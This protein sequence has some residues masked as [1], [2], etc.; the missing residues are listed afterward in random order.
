MSSSNVSFTEGPILKPLLKFTWPIIC[1]MFLQSAYSAVDLMILG[2]YAESSVAGV[3]NGGTIMTIVT[4]LTIGLVTGM[5]VAAGNRIGAGK[6]DE[7]GFCIGT[8]V[9]FFTALSAAISVII[10]V[11]AGVFADYMN[12]P[13]VSRS[14][15][16]TYV[17]ICGAGMIFIGG[18]NVI[19]GICQAAG[20][21]KKPLIF[22]FIACVIN[23]VTDYI[24]VA[25]MGT[26]A[27]GAAIATVAAQACSVVFAFSTL[28]K[29]R[30]Q[31]AW[32]KE[33]FRFRK[34][35]SL[36]IIKLGLPIG[37]QNSLT[38]FSFTIIIRTVNSFGMAFATGYSAAVRIVAFLCIPLK[39]FS[40]SLSAFIAHNF[41]AKKYERAR[42][43]LHVGMLCSFALSI[44]LMAVTWFGAEVFARLFVTTDD[45][46]AATAGY[47]HGFCFDN[48][49][50][51]FTFCLTGYLNGCRRTTLV[52]IQSLFAAFCIRAPF[53]LLMAG[54]PGVTMFHFGLAAP[55][56]SLAG[57]IFYMICL[58]VI[59]KKDHGT[60]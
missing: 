45:Y 57:C 6:N 53:A 26:G 60:I 20:N 43:S 44:V 36:E 39:A 24:L 56:A 17:R 42:K 32:S 11:F 19:A 34:A 49:I 40:V 4:N 5:T 7:A 3:G 8:G 13:D 1:S 29:T 2:K 41:G 50:G 58:A 31:F 14:A 48:L 23:I 54:I 25:I 27:A 51:C 16:L 21:S 55:A 46:I 38:S 12:V 47:L 35:E 52:M 28:K 59:R 22:A 15:F 33:L 30:F 18:Y 9:C 10:M 37:L